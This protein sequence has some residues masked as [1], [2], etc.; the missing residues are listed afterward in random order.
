MRATVQLLV[1]N[2]RMI[3]SMRNG[4]CGGVGVSHEETE[5]ELRTYMLNGTTPEELAAALTES[6]AEYSRVYDETEGQYK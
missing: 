3:R 6:E 2:R 1:D 5:A 4:G